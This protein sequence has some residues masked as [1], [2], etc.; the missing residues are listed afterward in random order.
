MVSAKGSNIDHII[1]DVDITVE[2]DPNSYAQGVVAGVVTYSSYYSDNSNITDT[3]IS[4]C[5]NRGT[6]T[7]GYDAG[8][9]CEKTGSNVTVKNCIN[10]GTVTSLRGRAGGITCYG[11][12]TTVED[13]ANLV[14]IS[15]LKGS[16][17]NC[18]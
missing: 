11:S 3:V 15:G 7:G 10:T 14:T 1:N 18:I 16:R 13:S 9:V 8:G 4:N 5:E 2:N 6:I 12:G 17:R